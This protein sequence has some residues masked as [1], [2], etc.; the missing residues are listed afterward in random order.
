MTA[1][2][3]QLVY[4]AT[5]GVDMCKGKDCGTTL[6]YPPII[7][8]ETECPNCKTVHTIIDGGLLELK[9]SLKTTK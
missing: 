2:Q 6:A 1:K 4:H 9:E 5:V 8:D 7:G 3:E